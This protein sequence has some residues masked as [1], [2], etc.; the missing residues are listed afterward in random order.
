M[1][2]Y[3]FTI[4][5]NHGERAEQ[6]APGQ[7]ENMRD[8]HRSTLQQIQFHKRSACGALAKFF[9]DSN[10]TVQI[11]VFYQELY[12][13]YDFMIITSSETVREGVELWAVPAWAGLWTAAQW[14]ASSLYD[15]FQITSSIYNFELFIQR[16]SCGLMRKD[17]TQTR[18]EL[19]SAR[20]SWEYLPEI[21]EN[22]STFARQVLSVGLLRWNV[23]GT[24]YTENYQEL[25]FHSK[26]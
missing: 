14:L 2:N 15:S 22:D 23:L 18:M 3:L 24:W 4:Y 6:A 7:L 17:C 20:L 25:I 10:T 1:Y 19:R 5:E 21:F 16:K 11:I 9:Y 8:S 26:S 13:Y 12:I